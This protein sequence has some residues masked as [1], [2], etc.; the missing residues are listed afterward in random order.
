MLLLDRS[1]VPT[2]FAMSNCVMVAPTALP[3][4]VSSAVRRLASLIATAVDGK[5][6]SCIVAMFDGELSPTALV[7][8]I[9]K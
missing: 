5:A 6:A 1:R 7:A 9:W 2:S 3:V 4:A 8:R